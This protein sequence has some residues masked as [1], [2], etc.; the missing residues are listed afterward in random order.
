[1]L[2]KLHEFSVLG[3]TVPLRKIKCFLYGL[4]FRIKIEILPS[5]MKPVCTHTLGFKKADRLLLKAPTWPTSKVSKAIMNNN[6]LNRNKAYK[7][8]SQVPS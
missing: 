1:M 4:F 2:A 6:D 3:H 8:D 5:M 7:F